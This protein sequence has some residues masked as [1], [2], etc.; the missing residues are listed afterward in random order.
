VSDDDF[1]MNDAGIVITE[2]TITGSKPEY[3]P[4]GFLVN[5]PEPGEYTL[6]VEAVKYEVDTGYCIQCG[7]CVEACPYEAL[8]LGY[9]YERAK[10]VY[11]A[12][13]RP[14][15]K[16]LCNK[17]YPTSEC[18]IKTKDGLYYNGSLVY[19][20]RKNGETC[21]TALPIFNQPL[22]IL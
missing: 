14:S 20:R 17:L 7:L 6:T 8:Y 22:I 3:G 15:D 21:R 4:G 16:F 1:G 12:V 9:D 5:A 13:G 2:T 19:R 18:Y 11:L 10:L